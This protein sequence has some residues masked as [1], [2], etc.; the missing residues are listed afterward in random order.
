[1][2]RLIPL[3]GKLQEVLG[4]VGKLNLGQSVDLPQIVVVGSQ[5]AGKSS[6]LESLVGH[7][8]LPRGS[9]IVTRR[10]LVLHVFTHAEEYGEFSHK[11]GVKFTDFT[12][13]RKE[14]ER[15]TDRVCGQNK[16]LSVHPILLKVF[17]PKVLNLTLV[18]T[19]GITKV[20]VGDQPKDIEQQIRKLVL[21]YISRP[22]ALILAL[23]AANTDLANSDA[24]KTAR[25]VDPDG[26]RTLGVITKLDLM[27]AGTHAGDILNNRVVP[28]RLGYIGIINRSQKDIENNKTIEAHLISEKKYVESHPVYSTMSN[29]GTPKLASKLNR[30]L[31]RHIAK[32]LPSLRK[33]VDTQLGRV[34][35][36]VEGLGE[37]GDF[38]DSKTQ[39]SAMLL[40]MLI[41]FSN[42]F[43]QMLDGRSKEIACAELKGGARIDFIFQNIFKPAVDALNPLN[44][45]SDEEIRMAVKNAQGTT[46]WLFIPQTSFERLA[47]RQ[48]A[49]LE[50]PSIQVAELIYAELLNLTGECE[51]KDIRNFQRLPDELIGVVKG[52]LGK[53]MEPCKEMI[54]NL[55]HIEKNYINTDHPDFLKAT[56]AYQ[57]PPPQQGNKGQPPQMQPGFFMQF[58][59]PTPEARTGVGGVIDSITGP[60][61][62][63]GKDWTPKERRGVEMIK[64]LLDV[65][66]GIVRRKVCDQVPKAIMALLVN[67]MKE[68][69]H[70]HLVAELYKD[71]KF[72][73]LLQETVEVVERRKLLKEMHSKLTHALALLDEVH[74]VGSNIVL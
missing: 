39:Q 65:Y 16:G 32:E 40:Q 33:R 13:I 7:E 74:E 38:S 62:T 63:G 3:I 48:I 56:Q 10:P 45:L 24:I 51:I 2:E 49:Q 67:P 55:L 14:I 11:P 26:Q 36:D 44:A 21:T 4:V 15:E 53:F 50:S 64:V 70:G 46:Q 12:E 8:F 25:E 43:S 52:L 30:E 27:D 66:F 28:M 23:T 68:Q 5:S 58:F 29:L 54:R 59:G 57:Q 20:P 73:Y 1:M 60:R 47:V 31:V 9:G 19:P 71:E 37:V 34:S 6:V 42:D 35:K 69:L 22:S 41:K 18:D 72:E 61:Q 17:S